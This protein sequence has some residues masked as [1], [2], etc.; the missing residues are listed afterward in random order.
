MKQRI[1]TGTQQREDASL[2]E[3]MAARI[4]AQQHHR[5]PVRNYRPRVGI[6]APRGYLRDGGWPIYG[7]DAPT[8]HAILEAGGLPCLIPTL[9]LIDGY[10]PF[11]LLTDEH[12]FALVFRVLWPVVRELD[13]LI[14]TGGGDLYA[15]LYGQRPHPQ[16]ETPDVWRDAWERYVALLAWLLCVPTLGMCRGMHLMNVALGGTLYQDLKAQWPKDRPPLLRHRARGRISSSNWVSHPIQLARPE[17]RL[18]RAV[19]SK[20]ELDRPSID[21]VLSMHHQA[22]EMLAPGLAVSATSPDGVIEAFE[23]TASY[24]WWVGTQFHPEWMTHLTW[25]HGLFTS[26]IHA[27]RVYA[28][29]PRDD[30]DALLEE[31]QGWLRQR[32]E[33]LNQ[34]SAP[35]TLLAETPTSHPISGSFSTL[36]MPRSGFTRS[37]SK[38]RMNHTETS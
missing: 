1:H 30:L 26:L 5:Q 13:G 2:S 15:C 31:I 14:F 22:V 21:Q 7:G 16:S 6:F 37:E 28:A 32:D 27:S 20:G 36:E 18:A 12:S 29:I 19:R 34:R 3:R 23:D 25:A 33:A 4:V 11:N 17:S 35:S 9:P 10:D 8:V 24:R 38:E